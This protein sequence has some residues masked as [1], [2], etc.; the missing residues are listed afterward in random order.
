MCTHYLLRVLGEHEIAHLWA[1]INAIDQCGIQSVPKLDCFISSSSSWCQDPMVMGAPGNS[2]DCC[3]MRGKFA[4][5][6]S[7]FSAPYEKLIVVTSRS[8]QV[9]VEWPLQSTN[10][11]RVTFIFWYDLIIALP[12]VS[13]LNGT[14]SR[15]AG[16]NS[17]APW[18]WAHSSAMATVFIQSTTFSDIPSLNRAF[19]CTYGNLGSLT[20]PVQAWYWVR[21]KFAKLDHSIVICVPKV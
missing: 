5:R 16:D 3:A 19:T 12:D 15:S 6:D 10:F 18:D 8:K 11:L 9:V 17:I 13:H 1:C 20:V 21:R 7:A 4:D 14:V 2:L